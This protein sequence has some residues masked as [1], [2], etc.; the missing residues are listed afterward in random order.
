MREQT[1]AYQKLATET[2]KQ[3]YV[4]GLEARIERLEDALKE[5]R[6]LLWDDFHH[7]VPSYETNTKTCPVCI[8]EQA[9]KNK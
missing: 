7:D 1:R 5:I 6:R 8:A 3:K 2:A 4:E 9:L